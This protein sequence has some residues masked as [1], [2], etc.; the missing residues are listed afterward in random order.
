MM[1]SERAI[2]QLNDLKDHCDSMEWTED[3]EA[4]EIGIRAIKTVKR[5]GLIIFIL[6]VLI[7]GSL[8]LKEPETGSITY[9]PQKVYAKGNPKR[10]KK[11]SLSAYKSLGKYTLTAYCGCSK[12]CGKSDG[13]TATGTKAK[14]G[15][16]IAVD[17]KVIPYGTKI[18]IGKN[19]YTAED[20]GGSIKGKH[21]DIFFDSHSKALDFGK[22]K[23][24]VYIRR[25]KNDIKK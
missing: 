3:V 5:I 1:N 6:F 15:H 19:I 10:S 8:E 7:I 12:C 22:Q 2:R 16:T 13:L 14:A 4:L 23:K 9:I 20:C 25:D 11:K 17:P 18:K 24:T 21:I